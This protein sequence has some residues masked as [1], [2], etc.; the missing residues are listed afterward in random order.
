M[1]TSTKA[2]TMYSSDL[3]RLIARVYNSSSGYQSFTMHSTT[4]EYAIKK[5][6]RYY[7]PVLLELYMKIVEALKKI[8]PK[9]V[10]PEDQPGKYNIIRAELEETDDSFSIVFKGIVYI[11]P[12]VFLR[13]LSLFLWYEIKYQTGSK[14]TFS[15]LG[16]IKTQK[17]KDLTDEVRYD[18]M[19]LPAKYTKIAVQKKCNFCGTST[20]FVNLWKMKVEGS[21]KEFETPVCNKHKIKRM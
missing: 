21:I 10:Y 3:Y 20:S 5:T 16:K 14:P 6:N 19:R 18:A 2:L 15:K 1:Y 4:L 12:A 9:Y 11:P 8:L 17:L 13:L 7:L